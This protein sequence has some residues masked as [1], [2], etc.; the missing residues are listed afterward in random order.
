MT[1][2]EKIPVYI[3][4]ENGRTVCVCHAEKSRCQKKDVC[5]RDL[6]TRDR[7]RG[8]RAT[9]KRDRYGQ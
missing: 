6:V 3:R 9:M 2:I 5:F 7:Y 1:D 8:W 4:I